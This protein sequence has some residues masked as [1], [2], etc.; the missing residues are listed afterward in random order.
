MFRYL[1]LFSL[2]ILSTTSTQIMAAAFQLWEQDGASIANYHAGYAALAADASTAFYNPAGITR[3]KNQQIVLGGDTILTDFKYRGTIK[4][5]TINAGNTAFTVTAQGGNIAFVPHLHY[6]A[7]LS[8]RLAFGFSVVVPFGLK[9]NY[10]STTMLRYA[11]TKTSVM[12]IN[13]S[14]VLAW[15]VNDQFSLGAGIDAQRMNAEFNSYAVLGDPETDTRSANSAEDTAYGYHIGALFQLSPETRFGL[16]YHSKVDHHL[17]GT[18]TFSGPLAAF[19]NDGIRSFSSRATTN[20]TLPAYTAF[21]VYQKVNPQIAMMG[22]VIYTQWNVFKNLVLNNLSGAQGMEKS[23]SIRVVIP[24]H[25]HNSWNFSV[26]GDYFATEQFILRGAI[27]YDQTP[28]NNQYRNPQLPDNNR[29][30][31]A[32]G[33]H[34]QATKTI[35]FDLGWSHLFIKQARVNPPTQVTG[36]QRTTTN[37][38][39]IGAGDVYGMQLTWDLV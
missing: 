5:N 26:G 34:Y 19:V 28:V 39:V 35:G 23:T 11:A 36:T 29:Y 4:V 32:L 38:N 10:G 1:R 6:V 27:G 7:P 16:S 20:V 17:K 14:P 33:G 21:S 37:G 12:V 15:Q 9:T 8:E 18:S 2:A 24:E 22:T 13:I 3:I 31:F 30:V 25:Y